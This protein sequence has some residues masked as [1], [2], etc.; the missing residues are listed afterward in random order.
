MFIDKE[1]TRGDTDLE[2]AIERSSG[3]PF[4]MTIRHLIQEEISVSSWMHET[5]IQTEVNTEEIDLHT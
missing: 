5:E 3:D 2:I 1:K 4:N